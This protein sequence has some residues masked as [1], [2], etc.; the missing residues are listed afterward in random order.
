MKEKQQQ[1]TFEKGITNVPSDFICSDNALQDCVG[2]TYAD[3]EHKVIQEPSLFMNE[4]GYTVLYVHKL[5]DKVRYIVTNNLYVG[6]GHKNASSNNFVFD[7]WLSHNNTNIAFTESTSITS[8]GKTLVVSD[9]ESLNYFLWKGSTY[10]SLGNMI[11]QPNVDFRLSGPLYWTE[12][13]D[14]STCLELRNNGGNN[15]IFVKEGQQSTYEDLVLGLYAK[16]DKKVSRDNNFMKPFFIRYALEL[17][18]GSYACHS[19]P[20]LLFPTVRK[21]MKATRGGAVSLGNDHRFGISVAYS[22]LQYTADFDYS[23]WEDIVKGVVVFASSGVEVNEL[24][25]NAGK[26]MPTESNGVVIPDSGNTVWADYV[27]SKTYGQVFLSTD[28]D[29]S[30]YIPLSQRTDNDIIDDLKS[31]SIFYKISELGRKKNVTTPTRVPIKEKVVLNLEEQLQL[32]DDYFSN[33]PLSAV[34]TFS[35]NQRLILSS[36]SRGFYGGAENWISYAGATPNEYKMF[37]TIEINVGEIVVEK[38]ITTAQYLDLYYF[39]PDP[40]AKKLEVFDSSDN[41][42]LEKTLEESPFLNG[43]F[44]IDRLPGALST[45][46][47]EGTNE[48]ENE[49]TESGGSGNNGGGFRRIALHTQAEETP[50]LYESLP[51][52]IYVSEV[53]NPFVFRP[54]GNVTVGNGEVVGVSS[55]TVALSQGQFGQYP[56]IIFTSEGIWAASTGTTGLFTAVHPMS[57]EVCNNPKSITQTDGLVFFSSEKGLMVVSGSVVKCVSEQLT[58]KTDT[59]FPDFLKT[60]IFAYDYRDSLLWI[61][62]AAEHEEGGVTH[63]GGRYCYIYNIKS[64]TFS[65]NIFYAAAEQ[66]E[67]EKYVTNVVPNYPDYLLQYGST[68]VSLINRPNINDDNNTYSASI[69][70][71]PMKLENGLALKTIMQ[72]KN[73]KQLHGSMTLKIEAS[74]DIEHWVEITSLTGTPWKFYRFTYEFSNLKATDTFSG[75]ILIT[76]E[77]RTNKLR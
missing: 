36:I 45:S 53:N 65:R 30:E 63:V 52:V 41:L 46:T 32:T 69:V 39:Y 50:H 33:C 49:G 76:Q 58:G 3:G 55:Q 13:G 21:N 26:M 34:S 1:L 17:F 5:V 70:S 25:D 6:W 67:T 24:D 68:V 15:M 27:T 48:S 20:I 61:F 77:R 11:P 23:D 19:V 59:P 74:N 54:E 12:H 31:S 73:I 2:M 43:A 9:G 64:D 28:I 66:G 51:N 37:I 10:Y 71:R 60:A 75:T 7:S 62:D 16:A 35:Y 57:R 22:I 72:L 44:F 38:E 56:L 42:V 18:D 4:C 40:R 8:I 47:N 29:K 14:A